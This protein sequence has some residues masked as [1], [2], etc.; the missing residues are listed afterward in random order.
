MDEQFGRRNGD[1]NGKSGGRY[2]G[3]RK[4]KMRAREERDYG[5]NGGGDG[6]NENSFEID[7]KSKLLY[8]IWSTD[9][10]LVTLEFSRELLQ[11][12][13]ILTQ[14]KEEKNHHLKNESTQQNQELRATLSET[15]TNL[16][17]VHTEMA[18]MRAEYE[19]KCRELSKLVTFFGIAKSNYRKSDFR[20]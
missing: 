17:L 20:E 9:E 7:P 5:K 14:N 1:T 8:V 13:D 3:E 15:T 6:W 19:T 2:Q 10:Y 18:R 16:A 4:T 11:V 12:N